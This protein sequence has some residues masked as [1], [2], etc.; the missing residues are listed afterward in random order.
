MVAQAWNANLI[1]RALARQTFQ[2]KHLVLVPECGWTGHE[3]D[4]LV[5]TTNL[6]VIDVE[7]K[8]SRADLRRDAG[9][10]KWFHS[11]DFALDGPW[12]PKSEGKRRPREWPCKV[13]KHY[14][15]V[16]KEIW[17]D[18][19]FEALPSPASGVLL[20]DR[21]GESGRW[22]VIQCQRRATPNRDAKKISPEDAVDIARLASLRMWDAFD[23]L[24]RQGVA[25]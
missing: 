14:L 2:S 13:W 17:D 22:L 1:A 11:W 4:L 16:P 25:P 9:K 7:I 21:R 15:A 10:D 20:L 12:T 8:I 23:A 19:L 18:G 3:C 5:V 24:A 6:R